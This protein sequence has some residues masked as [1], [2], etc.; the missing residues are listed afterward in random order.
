MDWTSFRQPTAG[1]RG[2]RQPYPQQRTE[3]SASS[4]EA[5]VVVAAAAASSAA[6]PAAAAVLLLRLPWSV[7]VVEW[8]AGSVPEFD[9][10]YAPSSSYSAL[11]RGR[12]LSRRFLGLGGLPLSSPNALRLSRGA[13]C[14]QK[15]AAAAAAAVVAAAGGEDGRPGGRFGRRQ[16]PDGNGEIEVCSGGQGQ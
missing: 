6:A 14:R 8:F 13:F 12:V 10:P 7:V 16:L 15:A 3:A 11:L 9:V 2:P 4:P 1:V 5:A